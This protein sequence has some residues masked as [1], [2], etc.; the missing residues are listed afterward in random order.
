LWNQQLA[1]IPRQALCCIRLEHLTVGWN[2]LEGAIAIVSGKVAGSV[3]LVGFGIDSAI[4]GF[5]GA[6]LLWR[7]HAERNGHNV[8]RLEQR[9]LTLVGVGFFLLAVYVAFDAISTLFS[10]ETSHR[11]AIGIALSLAS[12]IVIPLL[13]K[14]KRRTA[15]DLNRQHY[16]PI[17]SNFDLR[18]P[19][20]HSARRTTAECRRRMVVGWPSRCGDGSHHCAGGA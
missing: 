20:R 9:A 19:L 15:A 3:E 8:E 14:V 11:S 2:I 6:V 4:E 18:L 17:P 1:Y 7:F 12:R 16:R 10:R 13:A 5:S